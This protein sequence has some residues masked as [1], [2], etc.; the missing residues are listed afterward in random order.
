MG[1]LVQTSSSRVSIIRKD[2]LRPAA[3]SWR[4]MKLYRPRKL[5]NGT[6]NWVSRLRILCHLRQVHSCGA[7]D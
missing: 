6:L 1:P 2:L 7:V 4:M 3:A 5:V